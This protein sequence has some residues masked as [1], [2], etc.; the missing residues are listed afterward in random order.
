MLGPTHR[1]G[2]VAAGALVTVAIEKV[3]NIPIQDPILFV[4]ITMAGGAIG[5]LIPDI[6]S[7]SSTLGRDD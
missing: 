5:S 3:L 6:D 7:P 1:I 2:G 4:S